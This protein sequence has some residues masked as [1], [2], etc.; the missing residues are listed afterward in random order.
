MQQFLRTPFASSAAPAQERLDAELI[1][2]FDNFVDMSRSATFRTGES[3]ATCELHGCI[4]GF[5]KNGDENCFFHHTPG[6]EGI[7]RIVDLIGTHVDA[8]T[9]EVHLAV[10]GRYDA[11]RH[12]LSRAFS[13]GVDYTEGMLPQILEVLK[14]KGIQPQ[15]HPYHFESAQE[16]L[17]EER[18]RYRG[19]VWVDSTGELYVEGAPVGPTTEKIS[20]AY[21]H[22]PTSP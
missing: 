3:A 22:S 11:H 10:P 1:R 16:S 17:P 8:T 2:R 21:D 13:A 7:K 20:P 18:R 12:D 15:I 5:I 19:A 4:A 9:M 6:Y 14:Q